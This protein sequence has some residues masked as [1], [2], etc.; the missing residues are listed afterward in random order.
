MALKFP[1]ILIIIIMTNH[2]FLSHIQNAAL[3]NQTTVKISIHLLTE[4]ISIFPARY[5]NVVH[6]NTASDSHEIHFII[7]FFIIHLAAYPAGGISD[8]LR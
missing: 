5:K 4:T 2:S 6:N 1:D 8:I 7:V 3:T